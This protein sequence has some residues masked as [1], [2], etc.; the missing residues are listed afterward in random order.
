MSGKIPSLTF[1]RAELDHMSAWENKRAIR[2]VAQ[3]AVANGTPDVLVFDR[4]GLGGSTGWRSSDADLRV[5]ESI[6]KKYA[7][8]FAATAALATQI[9]GNVPRS[10]SSVAQKLLDSELGKELVGRVAE[11]LGRQPLLERARFGPRGVS[12]HDHADGRARAGDLFLTPDGELRR[13]AVELQNGLV[14]GV[15]YRCHLVRLKEDE[16]LDATSVMFGIQKQLERA[17][18]GKEMWAFVPGLEGPLGAYRGERSPMVLVGTK[19]S[20]KPSEG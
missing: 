10:D 17:R 6:A 18:E 2:D 11:H 3:K 4:D 7:E 20:G 12:L 1:T 9:L 8:Y 15:H 5:A 19:E 16:V 13:L 14:N